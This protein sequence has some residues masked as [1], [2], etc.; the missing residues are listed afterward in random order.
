MT[1]EARV[2]LRW[3]RRSMLIVARNIVATAAIVTALA[4]CRGGRSS[5][6]L[7]ET[8]EQV[9]ARLERDG[10]RVDATLGSGAVRYLGFEAF[11]SGALPGDEVTLVHYWVA[12]QQLDRP[13][14]V[15]VH[16]LLQGARGWVPHGDHDPLPSPPRWPIGSVIRD[17]HRVR[18]PAELPADRLELRVGL[19]DRDDRMP[20]DGEANNDGDD[21]I[22]AG[23]FEVSGTARPVPEYHAPR[24]KKPPALD[25]RIDEAE[26]GGAPWIEGFEKSV[27]RGLSNLS[28]RARLAWDPDH[29]YLAIIVEDPDIQG[30]LN[31]RD[32]PIYLQEAVEIFIDPTRSR[33]DYVELQVSPRGTLFD[34]AFSGGPRRNMTTAFNARYQVAVAIDGTLND[35][36]DVDR[37]WTTEW[38]IEVASIPGVVEKIK[39]G[40]NWRI[41]LFRVAKDR[42]GGR[43]VPDESAWS[44]PLMG[45][46]HNLERFGELWFD[47]ADS[48]ATA[49]AASG[50]S[51]K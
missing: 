2:E 47:D 18:L 49:G 37:S 26:W 15:F 20:V 10:S 21:R 14:R 40:T 41:N 6:V 25:G 24:L 11:P 44:P 8:P 33:R 30:T 23:G 35:P 39:G 17:E 38:S 1:A 50:V 4:G 32:A 9:L 16:F 13:Y 46:F 42:N 43:Q 3:A 19:Y 28:T 7:S 34:A 5:S 36:A 22:R 45:D 12:T 51:R 29:L 48:T 27:G 31:D